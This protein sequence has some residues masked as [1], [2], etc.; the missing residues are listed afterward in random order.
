AISKCPSDDKSDPVNGSKFTT[1]KQTGLP[2]IVWGKHR[3]AAVAKLKD[4]ADPM[5]ITGE[6]ATCI[7]P[8]AKTNPA[9]V[10]GHEGA[11]TMPAIASDHD[12]IKAVEGA[13]T[14]PTCM[15]DPV[16]IMGLEGTV[17]K[18]MVGT[19]TAKT[20]GTLSKPKLY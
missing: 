18:P 1:L 20:T 8:T 19:E 7:N 3:E 13:I 16:S 17:V 4:V 9:A 12:L 10:K 15:P 2:K 6:K 5:P 14:M 11:V